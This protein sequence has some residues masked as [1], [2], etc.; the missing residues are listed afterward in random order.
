[1]GPIPYIFF[2]GECAE[3][4]EFYAKIFDGEIMERMSASDMPPDF[5]VPEEKKD[6]VMHCRLQ[7]ADGGFMASDNIDGTSDKMAGSS[8]M[9]NYATAA[10][11]KAIFDKLADGGE[12]TMPWEP[13]FW[14][15]G[16]GTLVDRFGIRWM[17]GCDEAPS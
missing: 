6:W 8:L 14:A 13:T 17:V 3:A 2:N 7:T 11:A 5:P 15:A 9:M 4:M 10:E 1:M 12:I 16:F